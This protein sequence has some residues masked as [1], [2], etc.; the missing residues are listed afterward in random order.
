MGIGEQVL[1]CA[2]DR[3][4]EALPGVIEERDVGAVE[5]EGRRAHRNELRGK[6]RAA[7]AIDR[8][9]PAKHLA[10][11]G[12]ARRRDGLLGGDLGAP[13]VRSVVDEPGPARGGEVL[14]DA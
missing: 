4:A 13:L 9:V 2:V 12:Q 11:R 1:G 7:V 8:D 5:L 6:E 14:V 10:V 3:H